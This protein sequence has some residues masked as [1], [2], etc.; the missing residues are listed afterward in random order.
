MESLTTPLTLVLSRKGRG[1]K[2]K[3]KGINSTPHPTL[4]RGVE[5]GEKG[6]I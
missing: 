6:R 1:E 3:W 5:R 4:S 2:D